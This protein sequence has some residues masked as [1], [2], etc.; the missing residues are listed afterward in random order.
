[1]GSSTAARP[2]TTATRPTAIVARRPASSI[3]SPRPAATACASPERATARAAATGPASHRGNCLTSDKSLLLIKN[4]AD[5]DTKDKLIFK[6]IKGAAT[7]VEDFG[8]PAGTTS[9]ALC[10]YAGTTDTSIGVATIAPNMTFWTA[11][12]P[13][14][15]YKD[16]GG[17]SSGIQKVLLKSGEADKSKALVKGKGGGLPD[18][19]AGPLPLPVTAQLVNNANDVCYEGVFNI[20]KKNDTEQ[21]KAKNP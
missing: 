7:T 14:F 18:P 10:L 4:D 17:S 5:D 19:P 20:I 3:R 11:T 16:P 12:T 6:W 8:A 21:F 9:Y 1:M 13:G 2:A 15:K